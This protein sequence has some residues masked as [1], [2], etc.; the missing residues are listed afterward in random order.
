LGVTVH[1]RRSFAPVR[2]AV[3]APADFFALLDA[4]LLHM[5]DAVATF[6]D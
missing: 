4:G 2:L 5:P 3:S 1:H 6:A